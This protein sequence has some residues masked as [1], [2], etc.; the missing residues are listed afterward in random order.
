MAKFCSSKC[1]NIH[2]Q[3][4][5]NEKKEELEKAAKKEVELN[6][7]WKAD[8]I[9]TTEVPGDSLFNKEIIKFLNNGGLI[10]KYLNPVWAAGSIVIE[11]DDDLLD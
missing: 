9:T 6:E 1:R 2:K 8:A 3:N 5:A 10:T 11:Y 7:K 4:F